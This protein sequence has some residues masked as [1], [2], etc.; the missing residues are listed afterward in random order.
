MENSCIKIKSFNQ[1][2]ITNP[3]TLVICDID[4]TLLYWNKK[5]EDFY[6]MVMGNDP[7]QTHNKY[8]L[9]QEQIHNEALD[10][11]N[12]YMG[13]FPP[14]H[15]DL[16]GFTIL[17][18]QIKQT[19]SKLI[20]LTARTKSTSETWTKKNFKDIGLDYDTYQVH[21]TDNIIS[22]GDYIN[23]RIDTTPHTDVIFIDDLDFH[24]ESVCKLNSNIKCYQFEMD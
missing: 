12:M 15:T 18:E 23:L 22:K 14:T 4:K 1:I 8:K 7:I 13:I 9:T 11:L 5:P 2:Q 3:N 21:Y 17:Q 19:N 10:F 20:F 16:D 24:V 6:S